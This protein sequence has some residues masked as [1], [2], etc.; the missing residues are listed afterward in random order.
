LLLNPDKFPDNELIVFNR[1]GD[2]VFR[3]SPYINNWQGVNSKGEDLPDGTYY[4]ILRLNIGRGEI[5]R[6]DVTILR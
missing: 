6:G 1:W 3:A 4:Y 2:I 5:I